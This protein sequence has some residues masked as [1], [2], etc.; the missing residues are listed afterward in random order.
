MA[1]ANFDSVCIGCLEGFIWE[2]DFNMAMTDAK[3]GSKHRIELRE[4]HYFMLCLLWGD[5]WKLLVSK[6]YANFILTISMTSFLRQP[7][8]RFVFNTYYIWLLRS[9][10]IFLYLASTVSSFSVPI[11]AVE[12]SH[13]NKNLFF[14]AYKSSFINNT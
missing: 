9:F 7:A 3:T 4:M 14:G 8:V 12:I 11:S 1:Y 5:I 13:Y 10:F 2:G 6:R